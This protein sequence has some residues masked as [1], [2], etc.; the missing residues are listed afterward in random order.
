MNKEQIALL[1]LEG[2]TETKIKNILFGKKPKREYNYDPWCNCSPDDMEY[3]QMD[4]PHYIKEYADE[5]EIEY[6]RYVP[7]YVWYR[8]GYAEGQHKRVIDIIEPLLAR[9]QFL[10]LRGKA[11][12]H[13][14][15]IAEF[16]KKQRE[17]AMSR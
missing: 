1:L 8:F 9:H 6:H 11:D 13:H 5:Y 3:R 10:E 16:F 15:N 2:K 4:F 12:E 14:R 17:E 7:D